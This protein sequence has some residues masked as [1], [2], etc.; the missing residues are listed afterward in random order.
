VWG[1]SL[2][3]KCLLDAVPRLGPLWLTCFLAWRHWCRLLVC[4][5]GHIW[6]K[7][8]WIWDRCVFGYVWTGHPGVISHPWCLSLQS[9]VVILQEELHRV[10]SLGALMSHA[11]VQLWDL[12]HAMYLACFGRGLTAWKTAYGF[13]WVANGMPC[14][15]KACHISISCCC[16]CYSDYTNLHFASNFFCW[17]FRLMAFDQAPAQ[18]AAVTWISGTKS[19]FIPKCFPAMSMPSAGRYW[20]CS[21]GSKLSTSTWSATILG[22]DCGAGLENP[23]L[24]VQMHRVIS[25]PVSKEF[26]FWSSPNCTLVLN[27]SSILDILSVLHYLVQQYIKR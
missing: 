1:W 12:Y 16:Q 19:I 22:P 23:A 21:K 8:G 3:A 15:A 14:P 20:H 4:L 18:W 13:V 5:E 6:I 10:L 25:M 24:I 17:A 26:C 11:V 27:T 9:C 2:Y 7:L